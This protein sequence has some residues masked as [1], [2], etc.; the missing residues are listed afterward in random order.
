MAVGQDLA[1]F[2]EVCLAGFELPARRRYLDFM[3]RLAIPV[4]GRY[5]FVAEMGG[6]RIYSERV[7]KILAFEADDFQG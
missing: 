2:P 3:C 1:G 5:E 4:D 7:G 6:C